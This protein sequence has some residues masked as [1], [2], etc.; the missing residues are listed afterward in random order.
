VKLL[1]LNCKQCGAPIEVLATAEF[2]TCEFCSARLSVQH[3]GGTSF[4]QAL[5]ELRERTRKLEKTLGVRTVDKSLRRLDRSWRRRRKGFMMK[6]N[7]GVL[8]VPTRA[9]ASSYSICGPVIG[10]L[11]FWLLASASDSEEVVFC[12]LGGVIFPVTGLLGGWLIRKKADGYH[13]AHKNYIALR[14]KKLRERRAEAAR[15]KRTLPKD[16]SYLPS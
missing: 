15:P 11:F 3:T 8:R 1:A 16:G 7:D 6:G 10:I 5:D 9:I 2:V 12:V 4:T 13:D 14:R